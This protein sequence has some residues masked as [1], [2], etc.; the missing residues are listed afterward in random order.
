MLLTRDNGKIPHCRMGYHRPDC[1]ISLLLHSLLFLYQKSKH[2]TW[3]RRHFCWLTSIGGVTI[4]PDEV[5]INISQHTPKTYLVYM[6]TTMR[7]QGFTGG[8]EHMFYLHDRTAVRLHLGHRLRRLPTVGSSEAAQLYA[9]RGSGRSPAG[10]SPASHLCDG[11]RAG[12]AGRREGLIPAPGRRPQGSPRGGCSDE[13]DPPFSGRR[14][15]AGVADNPAGSP[16][17]FFTLLSRFMAGR[18]RL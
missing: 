9:H 14:T 3:C 16:L 7:S 15:P 4:C 8:T 6:K 17:T 5:R 1:S 18:V 13:A 10:S 11:A 2:F 12:R